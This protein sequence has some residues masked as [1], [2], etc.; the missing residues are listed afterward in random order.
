MKP[1]EETLDILGTI[2]QI[3]TALIVMVI[4]PIVVYVISFNDV[5]LIQL[6]KGLLILMLSLITWIII[7]ISTA[8]LFGKSKQ[9]ED[10]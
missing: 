6:Y 3:I 5:G 10:M 1:S 4:A 2:I 9:K 7:Y 8:R